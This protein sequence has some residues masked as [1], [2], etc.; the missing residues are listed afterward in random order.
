MG[1]MMR[2]RER[3]TNDDVTHAKIV[4]CWLGAWRLYSYKQNPTMSP[5][6]FHPDNIQFKTMLIIKKALKSVILETKTW[7]AER[8]FF[9]GIYIKHTSNRRLRNLIAHILLKDMPK[10]D[11]SWESSI[12]ICSSPLNTLILRCS[13]NQECKPGGHTEDPTTKAPSHLHFWPLAAE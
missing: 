13:S 3:G 4:V 11:K 5:W 2:K 6:E 7:C 1:E 9:G 12:L 8:T 10:E